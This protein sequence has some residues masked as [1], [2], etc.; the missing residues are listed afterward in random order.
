MGIVYFKGIGEYH[1]GINFGGEFSNYFAIN[2]G[3]IIAPATKAQKAKL[4]ELAPQSE[5]NLRKMINSKSPKKLATEYLGLKVGDGE[6]CGYNDFWITVGYNVFKKRM[7]WTP[8]RLRTDD[9][10]LVEHKFYSYQTEA[11]KASIL[12]SLNPRQH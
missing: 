1:H 4:S 12:K 10:V 8:D 11:A 7:R 5:Y 6:I 2:E 9:K 3:D